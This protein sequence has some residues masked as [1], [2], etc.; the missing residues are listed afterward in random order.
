MPVFGSAGQ[1]TSCVPC[2]LEYRQQGITAGDVN[3]VSP[4]LNNARSERRL[5][6]VYL[7]ELARVDRNERMRIG[8]QE[9]WQLS[10]GVWDRAC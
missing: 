1:A 5:L 4:Q 8:M 7:L 9:Y 3:E 2:G 6:E 10:D